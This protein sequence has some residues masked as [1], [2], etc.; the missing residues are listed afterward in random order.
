MPKLINMKH[1]YLFIFCSLMILSSSAQQA[2]PYGTMT[3]IFNNNQWDSVN[4]VWYEYNTNDL[5]ERATHQEFKPTIMQWFNSFK[6]ESDYNTQGDETFELRYSWNI[7][8]TSWDSNGRTTN[9]YYKQGLQESSIIETYSIGWETFIIDS[10]FYNANDKVIE[11]RGYW[12]L[13]GSKIEW[14]SWSKNTFNS[15]NK[16]SESI[17][18]W[19]DTANNKWDS[20]YKNYFGYNTILNIDTITSYNYSVSL[21]WQKSSRSITAF[22]SANR[23]KQYE[24]FQWDLSTMD[25]APYTRTRYTYHADGSIDVIYFD[26]YDDVEKDYLGYDK[27]TFLYGTPAGIGRSESKASIKLFPNPVAEQL[28]VRLEGISQPVIGMIYSADGKLIRNVSLR[29]GLNSINTTNWN[30]GNYILVFPMNENMNSQHFIK[31]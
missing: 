13:N 6:F 18:F 29:S 15:N 16:L 17:S 4:R 23:V 5:E 12:N 14:M 26:F 9:T 10:N 20:T 1:L 8:T 11:R 24:N 19:R 25:W 3:E 30:S 27:T 31:K 21:G 22:D 28:D 2:L 7:G